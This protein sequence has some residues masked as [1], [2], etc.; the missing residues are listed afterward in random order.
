MDYSTAELKDLVKEARRIL[1]QMAYDAGSE[2][3]HVGPAL[4]IIDITTVLYLDV[5]NHKLEDPQW[6]DRDRFILSKGHACLGL[7][8]PLVMRGIISPE[9]KGTFNRAHTTLAGHPSG[10]G[11]PGIEHPAGSLGHGLSVACGIAK[12]GKIQRKTYMTYTLIGDGETNEGSIWEAVMFA[13]QHKLD[14]L[15][16]IVDANKWQFGNSTAKI[17]DMEPMADK[18][19]AFGWNVI[20]ID[21]HNIEEIRAAFSKEK[22]I[23]DMPTCI[24]ANT[25][26]GAGLSFTENDNGWHHRKLTQEEFDRA[27]KELA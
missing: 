25:I 8:V 26:K 16:A 10:I 20:I 19:K 24:I 1:M 14:N 23:K 7:Y 22:I 27:W 11:V 5:I 15:V 9:L 2:G 6:E 12:G 4:S 13:K 18:W 3:A 21:G 17:M